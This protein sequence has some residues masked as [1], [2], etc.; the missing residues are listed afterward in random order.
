MATGTPHTEPLTRC[1][2]QAFSSPPDVVHTSALSCIVADL[3]K[4]GIS[5]NHK[6]S[7]VHPETGR[8]YDLFPM[9]QGNKVIQLV[10]VPKSSSLPGV[11]ATSASCLFI[12]G[13][14]LDNFTTVPSRSGGRPIRVENAVFGALKFLIFM[15]GVRNLKDTEENRK[16][17]GDNLYRVVRGVVREVEN[18]KAKGKKEYDA[19]PLYAY[20]KEQVAKIPEEQPAMDVPA[21]V[22]AYEAQAAKI[23]PLLAVCQ[24]LTAKTVGRS[25]IFS[26]IDTF[27]D[28]R[29]AVDEKAVAYVRTYACMH[30]FGQT[31]VFCLMRDTKME[32][33]YVD[34]LWALQIPKS[35]LPGELDTFKW[36]GPGYNVEQNNDFL[37]AALS[38]VLDRKLQRAN[39]E[40]RSVVVSIIQK[41]ADKL[42]HGSSGSP[43]KRSKSEPTS[44]GEYVPTTPTLEPFSDT[45]LCQVGWF[46]WFNKHVASEGTNILVPALALSES[47]ILCL[48]QVV[49]G[50][51]SAADIMETLMLSA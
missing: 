50:N 17:L 34:D 38:P 6:I 32:I 18:Q 14:I 48:G 16:L 37:V 20:C 44:D 7:W 12:K 36:N 47:E 24:P 5:V 2:S 9:E 41:T 35:E 19:D 4:E 8:K 33:S 45:Y 3:K 15:D 46:N 22:A 28:T 10:C 11:D 40:A 27:G 1:L 26:L 31:A 51:I 13:S 30:N 43:A 39:V 21:L 29:W 42:K 23:E 25:V 49:E